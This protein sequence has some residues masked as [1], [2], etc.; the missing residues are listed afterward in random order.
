[1]HVFFTF[2]TEVI[3]QAKC[4]ALPAKGETVFLDGKEYTVVENVWWVVTTA[5]PY[6]YVHV[7]LKVDARPNTADPR[8]E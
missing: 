7:C 2:G 5:R 1:M 8:T 6:T 3:W 4:D